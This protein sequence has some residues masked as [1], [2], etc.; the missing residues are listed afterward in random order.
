M[1]ANL[2][3]RTPVAAFPNYPSVDRRDGRKVAL[4]QGFG[5]QEGSF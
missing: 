2:A 1:S 4:G 5:F 3:R